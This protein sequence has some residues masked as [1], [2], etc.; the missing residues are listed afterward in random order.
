MLLLIAVNGQT[1][2]LIP[3]FT[4]GVFVGLTISQVGLVRHGLGNNHLAA[5]ALV[6]ETRRD[7]HGR[8]E[9]VEHVARRD[10]DARSGVKSELQHDGRRA[11][12]FASGGVEACDIVLDRERRTDC[13]IRPREG[14]HDRIA[15]GLDDEAMMALHPVREERKWSRT[16]L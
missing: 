8:A 4:I 10:G 14:G 5:A 1:N 13:V 15:H 11:R 2:K 7:I 12:T 9:I 3:L 6:F 16:R